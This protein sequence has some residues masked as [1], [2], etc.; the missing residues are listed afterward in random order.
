M[1]RRRQNAR[2]DVMDTNRLILIAG[3]VVVVLLLGYYMLAPGGV[4]PQKSTVGQT[5]QQR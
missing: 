1:T 4:S 5:T 2:E 3:A